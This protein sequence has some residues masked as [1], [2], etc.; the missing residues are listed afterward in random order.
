MAFSWPWNVPSQLNV[1]DKDILLHCAWK[2]KSIMEA[3]LIELQKKKNWSLLRSP[4]GHAWP[5]WEEAREGSFL[6]H[7]VY[8]EN[9]WSVFSSCA[10][11]INK[12]TTVNSQRLL[13]ILT[14]S[15]LTNP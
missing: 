5:T 6:L 13:S 2:K 12:T 8:L 1:E 7:I 9:S 4:S 3:F 15:N 11:V 14:E 10:S